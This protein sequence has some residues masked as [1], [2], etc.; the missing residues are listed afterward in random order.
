MKWSYDP[1]VDALAIV[2]NSNKRSA[3]TVEQQP[4][5]I[6]DYDTSGQLISIELLDAS[7][8]VSKKVLEDIPLPQTMMPLTK[9]AKR[10]GLDPATLRQQIRRDRLKATKYH[11]EWWVD[12]DALND[13]LNNRGPQG[14]PSKTA[15]QAHR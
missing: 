13:Y 12:E 6:F 9:A 11:R 14:R 8:Q 4:G 2:F 10:A 3:S 15:M 5:V 1:S 7:A